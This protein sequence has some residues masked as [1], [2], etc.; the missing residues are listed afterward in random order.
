M[1]IMGEASKVTSRILAVG[2][3]VTAGEEKIEV[4]INNFMFNAFL[5]DNDEPIAPYVGLYQGVLQLR[6]E[7]GE[8]F[9][10]ALSAEL[11]LKCAPAALADMYPPSLDEAYD[12]RFVQLIDAAGG[13]FK[14]DGMQLKHVA[15]QRPVSE[16]TQAARHVNWT[17]T[18]YS[19]TAKGDKLAVFIAATPESKHRDARVEL[20]RFNVIQRILVDG[21]V[22]KDVNKPVTPELGYNEVVADIEYS[23]LT[24]RYSQVL[25]G[26]ENPIIAAGK[27]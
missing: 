21:V 20:D 23:Y 24:Q 19:E 18:Q 26:T 25:G 2:F 7:T 13:D 6:K 5:D 10:A 9:W 3:I 15:F 27:R 11:Q 22:F 14:I 12:V 8:Y 17:L 16:S 4:P 1:G